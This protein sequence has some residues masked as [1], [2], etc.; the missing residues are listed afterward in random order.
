M[1]VPWVRLPI[2]AFKYIPQI[3]TNYEQ[4]D[5]SGLCVVMVISEFIV[6]AATVVQIVII[7]YNYNDISLVLGNFSKFFDGLCTLIGNMVFLVQYF[8]WY[9]KNQ[10]KDP[11]FILWNK[12][13]KGTQN[14]RNVN[15]QITSDSA[16][17]EGQ[18]AINLFQR[19]NVISYGTI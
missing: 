12:F 1:F 6:G 3:I 2:A 5:T 11:F 7:R 19:H 15:F 4:E 13:G 8:Y 9:K 18:C 10:L 14:R 16:S 17:E